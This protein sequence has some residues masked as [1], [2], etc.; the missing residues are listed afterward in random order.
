MNVLRY[1]MNIWTFNKCIETYDKCLDTFDKCLETF[2]KWNGA[3]PAVH[4]CLFD[5]LDP[6]CEGSK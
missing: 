6:T 5:W 2:D 4:F 3:D 1:L